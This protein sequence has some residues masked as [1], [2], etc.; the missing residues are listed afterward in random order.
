MDAINDKIETLKASGIINY[1]YHRPIKIEG[2]TD[3]DGGAKALNLKS[4]SGAFQVLIIGCV[5]CFL[6]LIYEI[7]THRMIRI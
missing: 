2:L 6:V 5:L 1:L 3:S 4:L 7:L